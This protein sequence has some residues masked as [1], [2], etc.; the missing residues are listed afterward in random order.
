MLAI[1]M[2]AQK[3]LAL[4]QKVRVRFF[5]SSPA[6]GCFNMEKIHRENDSKILKGVACRPLYRKGK[7]NIRFRFMKPSHAIARI[8][9]QPLGRPRIYVYIFNY[10]KYIK[11]LGNLLFS[12]NTL[13]STCT[14]R[15][16]SA[17]PSVGGRSTG[18]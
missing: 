4:T 16:S 6:G 13:A 1:L 5:E 15:L 11:K 9:W 12:S 8:N 14:T 2:P 3:G 10:L 18:F 7:R 17:R